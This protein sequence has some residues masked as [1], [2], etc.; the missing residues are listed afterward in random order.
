MERDRDVL[1]VQDFPLLGGSDRP[2]PSP[3]FGDRLAQFLNYLP[4]KRL[5]AS[6]LKVVRQRCTGILARVDFGGAIGVLRNTH[7]HLRAMTMLQST[8]LSPQ[9]NI[10]PH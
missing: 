5:R 4:Y 2:P 1:F 9:G 8:V 6:E 7:L 10:V 3:Q